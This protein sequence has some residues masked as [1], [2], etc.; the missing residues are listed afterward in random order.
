MRAGEKV[1]PKSR[2]V[3]IDKLILKQFTKCEKNKNTIQTSNQGK[4]TS[5]ISRYSIPKEEEIKMMNFSK[6]N[7]YSYIYGLNTTVS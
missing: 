2:K 4:I 1:E 3:V 7:T 6:L 5:S